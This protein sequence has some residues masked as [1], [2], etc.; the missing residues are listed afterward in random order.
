MGALDPRRSG[1]GENVEEDQILFWC[2]LVAAV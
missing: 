1:E 2:I